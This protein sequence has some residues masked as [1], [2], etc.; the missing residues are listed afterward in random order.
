MSIEFLKRKSVVL[1]DKSRRFCIL[2]TRKV[3][4][5]ELRWAKI[6]RIDIIIINFLLKEVTFSEYITILIYVTVTK[7]LALFYCNCHKSC[8]NKCN[9]KDGQRK[10]R[11]TI[12]WWKLHRERI[13]TFTIS[14][15]CKF[16]NSC[17]MRLQILY[18]P[19]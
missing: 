17:S 10:V 15:N 11:I 9:D 14:T 7:T 1:K 19:K 13:S 3:R 6:T 5:F 2:S 18:R 12:K 4:I 16:L 8:F